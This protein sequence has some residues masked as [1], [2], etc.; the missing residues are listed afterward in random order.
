MGKTLSLSLVKSRGA[1]MQTSMEVRVIQWVLVEVWKRL[2]IVWKRLADRD[3]NSNRPNAEVALY[4][5]L[6]SFLVT[7]PAPSVSVRYRH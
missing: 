3:K 1:S 4:P 2:A 5:V 6:C 7:V